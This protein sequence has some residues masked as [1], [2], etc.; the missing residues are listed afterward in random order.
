MAIIRLKEIQGMSSE[1]RAKKLVDLRVELARIKT[2]V[3]AGGAVENPTKVREL[4]KTI[5]QILTVE[6]EKKLG[7]GKGAKEEEEKPKKKAE[8]PAKAAKAKKEAEETESE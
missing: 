4:R 1:D 2:M 6:N 7:I 8:K 3:N 5:A